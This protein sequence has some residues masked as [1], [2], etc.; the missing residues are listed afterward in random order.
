MA[1]WLCDEKSK[2]WQSASG[3]F[4]KLT[5]R[6]GRGFDRPL[7]ESVCIVSIAENDTTGA[8]DS[9]GDGKLSKL[10]FVI[11]DNIQ[12]IIGSPQT[13]V[14]ATLEKCLMTMRE[15]EQSLFLIN[16]PCG[17]GG[18]D[19]EDKNINITVNIKLTLHSLAGV[20]PSWDLSASEKYELALCHKE[21]G[22]EMFQD[23]TEL[24]FYEFGVAVKYLITIPTYSP[25]IFSHS[26]ISQAEKE[27]YDKLKCICYLNLAACQAKFEN[28]QGVIQ[29]CCHALTLDPSNLKGLYRRGKAYLACGKLEDAQK[30]LLKM[31][32]L[33]P[34]NR[35]V[36]SL[37][38]QMKKE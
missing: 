1:E 29:N 26:G 15:D 22:R 32:K 20:K 30:D 18:S 2:M 16:L 7:L 38:N 4:H 13:V 25:L 34:N 3:D 11:G 31:S 10:G 6:E 19:G 37:L 24:A 27:E 35:D 17:C 8:S 21:R 12:V 9:L 28:H 23:N 5:V 33:A 14:M 36:I